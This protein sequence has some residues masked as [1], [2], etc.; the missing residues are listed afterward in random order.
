MIK[1]AA[2]QYQPGEWVR[3]ITG[4]CAGQVGMIDEVLAGWRFQ[5]VWIK[6]AGQTPRTCTLNI[7]IALEGQ[8][9]SHES[10]T[11]ERA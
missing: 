2:R 8:E 7:H 1:P 4:Q 3:V 10:G 11:N 5:L 6:V 9:A